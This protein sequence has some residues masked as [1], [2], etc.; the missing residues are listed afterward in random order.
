MIFD[1]TAKDDGIQKAAGDDFVFSA[2]VVDDYPAT[3]SNRIL[4]GGAVRWYH[5]GGVYLPSAGFIPLPVKT[6]PVTA[7]KMQTPIR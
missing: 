5:D 4:G 6:R 3:L 1:N 7:W 2:F